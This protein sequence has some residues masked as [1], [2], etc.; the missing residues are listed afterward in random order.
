[1][2]MTM[3]V[4]PQGGRIPP[5]RPNLTPSDGNSMHALVERVQAAREEGID[6]RATGVIEGRQLK[7]CLRIIEGRLDCP[8]GRHDHVHP[9]LKLGCQDDRIGIES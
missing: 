1:M 7:R 9:G 2:T 4:G 6:F 3:I 8:G 5:V